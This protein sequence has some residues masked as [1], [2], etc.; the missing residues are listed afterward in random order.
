MMTPY[1]PAMRRPLLAALLMLAAARPLSPLLATE[2]EPP[3]STHLQLS[4]D[5]PDAEVYI[6][7]VLRGNTP[8]T[9]SDLTP[10]AHLVHLE[11]RDHE[12]HRQTVEVKTGVMRSLD[13]RLEPLTGLVLIHSDPPEAEIIIDGAVHGTT[14]ALITDLPFGRY[15]LKLTKAGFQEQERELQVENR[16]PQSV[17]VV[18]ASDSATVTVT[19]TPAGGSVFIDGIQRGIAPVTIERIPEGTVELS[20]QCDGFAPFKQTIKVAAGEN[21]TIEVPLAALPGSLRIV[22]IPAGA[23]IYVNNDFRGESP[24]S[25]D[26]VPPGTYRIRA[27]LQAYESMARTVEISRAQKVVEEFRLV[28]NNGRME[29]TTEPAGVSL[30]VD[31]KLVG[32][33]LAPPGET[34]RLSDPYAVEQ[35]TVGEHELRLTRKGYYDRALPVVIERGKTLPVHGVLKRRFVPDYEVRTAKRSY[36]GVLD[37]ISGGYLRLETAPGIITPI[38]LAEITLR[39][40]LRQDEPPSAP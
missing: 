20:V 16:I 8:L 2:E 17:R 9:L 1:F 4:S 24:V 5:P 40:P 6:D 13:V 25:L 12:P 32:E 35:I 30:Y 28:S 34:D 7:R 14:P 27:E 21:Q 39:R 22:T 31:G 10:G 38:P 18:L 26:T 3:P 29:V 19:T 36:K 37:S 15:R 11:K 33:T 23:R